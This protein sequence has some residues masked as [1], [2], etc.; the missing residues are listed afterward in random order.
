MRQADRQRRIKLVVDEWG[1]WHKN[2]PLVDPSHLF[3]SQS[4]IRDALVTGLSLDIFHRHADK[5]GMANVAQMINCIHSLFF[6]HE[7]KFTVTPAYHVFAMYAAHQ[8]AQSVRTLI[9]APRVSWQAKDGHRDGF[10]GLAGSASR[11]G[12]EVT[13]TVTNASLTE[14]RETEVVLRGATARSAQVTTLSA[15]NVHDVNTFEHPDVIRPVPSAATASGTGG[16]YR[17][18]PA[19]VTKV[20]MT[21]D[22]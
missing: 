13:L 9:A 11:R 21:I 18:P 16:V 3:E 8:G 20:A 2:A 17:F 10:W 5:I 7:E 22:G 6:A 15:G 12:R 19:S 1:A 4:T 14:T